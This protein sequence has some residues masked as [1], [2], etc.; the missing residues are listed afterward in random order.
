[1]TLIFALF[2]VAVC[3]PALGVPAL[4]R[5]ALPEL[6][7]STP[8]VRLRA[9]V[10]AAVRA[11]HAVPAAGL[12]LFAGS[13]AVVTVC[14]PLGEGL[15]RLEPVLD[16]PVFDYVA[17][18]RV[19]WWAQVN[20]A[21]TVIGE[22]EPLKYVTVAAALIFGILWG[23]RWLIPAATMLGQFA[24]EQYTQQILKLVVDR[25]HPPTALGTFPS[26]GCARVLLTFGAILV[27]AARTWRLSRTAQVA[28]ATALAVAVMVEG[29]T[30]VYVQKHWLTDVVGGWVFGALLLGVVALTVSIV[31]GPPPAAVGSGSARPSAAVGG[32]R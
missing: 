27:L 1:M 10:V 14:W 29:Y 3:V 11:L 16:R 19:G 26:G 31:A 8:V 6:A 5:R 30:R 21:I 20:S 32:G 13:T 28:G 17:A 24:L 4:A 15:S 25:G 18:H 9:A 2:V 23:R 22:R 12:A 7:A